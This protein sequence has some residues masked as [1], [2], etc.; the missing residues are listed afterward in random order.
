MLSIIVVVV[1]SSIRVAKEHERF[2][3]F[4]LGRFF[5]L[6]G[7]GLII[8]APFVQESIRLAIGDK[9]RFK[10]D[11]IAECQ[12]YGLPVTTDAAVGEC[13]R[14]ACVRVRSHE[15]MQYAYSIQRQHD[16]ITLKH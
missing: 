4:I 6:K 2:A 8:R 3:V 5:A 11:G 15:D 7:P 1:F 9:G 10:G 12:E 13:A 16:V 14:Q